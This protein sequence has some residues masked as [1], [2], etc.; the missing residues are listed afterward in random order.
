M[1][2]IYFFPQPLGLVQSTMAKKVD[3]ADETASQAV[4]MGIARSTQPPTKSWSFYISMFGLALVALVT[5]WDAT[6]L[7]IALPVG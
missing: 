1:N 6:A 4:E 7:A 2:N 5:A 3:P